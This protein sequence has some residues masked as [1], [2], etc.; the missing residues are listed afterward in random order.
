M[1]HSLGFGNY[2]L[3]GSINNAQQ[4]LTIYEPHHL[5]EYPMTAR[6]SNPRKAL[7]LV[8]LLVVVT[9]MVLL[10][11]VVLAPGWSGCEVVRSERQLRV[12]SVRSCWPRRPMR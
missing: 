8:E 1:T 12:R 2:G 5:D 4:A 3:L 9:I 10:L 11:G 7:T 6:V